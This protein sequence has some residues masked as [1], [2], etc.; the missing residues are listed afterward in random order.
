MEAAHAL[1]EFANVAVGGQ[2]VFNELPGP[3]PKAALVGNPYS[4]YSPY[5]FNGAYFYV[6]MNYRWSWD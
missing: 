2:N 3:N 1:G 5:G 6:R 4:Q